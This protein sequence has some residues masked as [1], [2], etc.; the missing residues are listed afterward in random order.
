MRSSHVTCPNVWQKHVS[1]R[2]KPVCVA[3]RADSC[4]HTARVAAATLAV[5]PPRLR[6]ATNAYSHGGPANLP[7]AGCWL[8]ERIKAGAS[9]RCWPAAPCKQKVLF[10]G[11]PRW[12]P[13]SSLGRRARTPRCGG[14]WSVQ[15][16]KGPM[17]VRLCFRMSCQEDAALIL[18]I[19]VFQ[20]GRSLLA[21]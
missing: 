13:P 6:R 14:R 11:A 8:G 15:G 10:E 19:V 9:K 12:P 7:V 20:L 21:R 1:I 16:T 18:N 5:P 2:R 4:G 17:M 3:A